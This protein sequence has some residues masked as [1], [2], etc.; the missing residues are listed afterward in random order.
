M[1]HHTQPTQAVDLSICLTLA[2]DF[3]PL[4]WGAY[5]EDFAVTGPHF[6]AMSFLPV[7]AL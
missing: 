6:R 7:L 1:L 2:L 5:Q 3:K 4:L